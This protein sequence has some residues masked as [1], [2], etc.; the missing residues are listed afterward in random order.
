MCDRR[1]ARFHDGDDEN[2]AGADGLAAAVKERMVVRDD[3]ARG[4]D[5]EGVEGNDAEVEFAGGHFHAFGVG[6][7]AAFG[8]GLRV[9]VQL[10]Q[11]A[12]LYNAGHLRP[13]I[14]KTF[15]FDQTLDALAYAEQGRANGK[16]VITLDWQP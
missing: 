5:S 6:E 9:L 8:G 12:T 15:P 3:E 16:V 7:G 4:Q 1:H 2:G 13:I 11:L 10:R 14:D